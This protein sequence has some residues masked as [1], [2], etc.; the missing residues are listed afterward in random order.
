M[1]GNMYKTDKKATL[2]KIIPFILVLLLL[3]SCGQK[4]PDG[5]QDFSSNAAG[6]GSAGSSGS[7]IN[8]ANRE[9]LDAC[10]GR[11]VRQT[12]E[13]AD[14][15]NITIEGK[16]NVGGISRVTRYKYIPHQYTEE[17]R[18]TWFKHLLYSETW[19]AN[20]A[21]VYHEE[22]GEWEVVTP[23]GRRWVYRVWDDESFAEQIM[24]FERTDIGLDY[25]QEGVSPAEISS[26]EWKQLIRDATGDVPESVEYA[27]HGVMEDMERDDIYSCSYIDICGKDS[28]RPYTKSSYRRI[29][30]GMPVTVWHNLSLIKIDMGNP[31]RVWGSLFSAEELGLEK[32]IL[33]F[34]EAITALEYL[35]VLSADGEPEIVPV[36]R[37]YLGKDDLERSLLC[38]EILAVNA[39]NGELIW[40]ER[41]SF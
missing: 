10:A 31:V 32:P 18:Q 7:G 2:H 6:S 17:F 24:N 33:S 9:I 22:K 25:T 20:K 35:S 28:E 34:D 11:F 40:E 5:G 37:F 21:A 36:W 15:K 3:T 23:I 16:V 27:W 38:E 4:T 41:E 13:I 30:D 12:I 19:D 14:G 29:L 8:D 26:G 39:I 1:R